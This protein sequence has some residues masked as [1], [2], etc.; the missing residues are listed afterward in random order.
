MRLRQV[1]SLPAATVDIAGVGRVHDNSSTH[2][3]HLLTV[4][5]VT[6]RANHL[7]YIISFNSHNNLMK[8]VC[9]CTHEKPK[10]REIRR[11]FRVTQPANG[12]LVLTPSM[13]ISEV[14]ASDQ[15]QPR[16]LSEFLGPRLRTSLTRKV[17]PAQRPFSTK[18]TLSR[19]PFLCF[20]GVKT[21][22]C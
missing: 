15:C 16:D 6:Q 12:E 2:G 10:L 19:L 8:H 14:Q 4:H 1:P 5:H 21:A 20:P 9:R 17:R 7:E 22:V 18:R 3:Y 13:P 11:L